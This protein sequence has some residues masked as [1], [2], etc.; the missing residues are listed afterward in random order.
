MLSYED[1]SI[2]D[3]GT[4]TLVSARALLTLT[5]H[6]DADALHNHLDAYADNSGLL[7]NLLRALSAAAEETRTRAETARRIWPN[8]MRRVLDLNDTGHAPFEDHH[9]GDMALASLLPNPA[10]DFAYFHREFQDEPIRWWTPLAWRSEIE[11]WLVLAAGNA[12]CVD[13]LIIFLGILTPEDQVRAGL[14]WVATLVLADPDHVANRSYM[15]PS[16]LIETRATAAEAGLGVEWQQV[17]DALAVA[18]RE[19]LAP[20]SV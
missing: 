14:P 20:Y 16:W 6:D 9:Y 4:H 7:S 19:Q 11:A 15:C 12:I 1:P 5:E 17:V 2:D 8:I 18:G 13:Q 10:P 3:R